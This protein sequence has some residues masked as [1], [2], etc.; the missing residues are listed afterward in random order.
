MSTITIYGASDD[1]VEVEGAIREEYDLGGEGTRLRLTAPDGD[2][3]DVY[4]QF[5]YRHGGLDWAVTVEAV[6]SYPSWPIFF[7]ERPGYE[8]DPAVSIDAPTGTTIKVIR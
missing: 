3:L 7:H 2:S 4:A 1:L 8:G 6:D 5:G